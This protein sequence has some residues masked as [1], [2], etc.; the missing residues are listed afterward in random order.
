[1]AYF[2]GFT[3]TDDR[4]FALKEG[5]FFAKLKPNEIRTTLHVIDLLIV[6]LVY[7]L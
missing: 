2:V 6:K 5:I 3:T 1:M 4:S 7:G